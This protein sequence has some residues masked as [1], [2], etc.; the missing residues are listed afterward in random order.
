[1]TFPDPFPEILNL[2]ANGI[3]NQTS[4]AFV[5]SWSVMAQV[6][7]SCKLLMSSEDQF[8]KLLSNDAIR[9]SISAHSLSSKRPVGGSNG[10]ELIISDSTVFMLLFPDCCWSLAKLFLSSVLTDNFFFFLLSAVPVWLRGRCF[11]RLRDLFPSSTMNYEREQSDDECWQTK[12]ETFLPEAGI[13][14]FKK[15]SSGKRSV[16]TAMSRRS[17]IR[18]SVLNLTATFLP[19]ASCVAK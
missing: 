17:G 18:W 12:W 7:S 9:L 10:D 16:R 11:V 14:G 19:W 15:K 13:S 5:A 6:G 8:L 4:F 1:M 2:N 3:V